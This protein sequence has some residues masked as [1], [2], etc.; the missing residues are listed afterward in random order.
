[1]SVVLID[2]SVFHAVAERL[3]SPSLYDA[4]F[5]I[6][7]E[8]KTSALEFLVENWMKLNRAT[9]KVIDTDGV[10]ENDVYEYTERGFTTIQ[11]LKNLKFIRQ[12][13]D[14]KIIG[15]ENLK[16]EEK[17]ALEFLD[18]LINTVQ[19]KFI[20]SLAEYQDAI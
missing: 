3:V 9:Y 8:W 6:C 20:E 14:L 13:I 2:L 16:F 17:Y 12:N 10:I 19:S 4:H 18:R 5:E 1:M 15:L 11:F 7:R